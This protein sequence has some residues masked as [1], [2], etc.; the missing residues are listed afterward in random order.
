MTIPKFPI[1]SVILP[2]SLQGVPN[3]KLP[4]EMLYPFLGHQAGSN[5]KLHAL[6][7]WH[8]TRL[9]NDCQKATGV[10]LTY[11]YGGCYRTYAQQ[12]SLFIQRYEPVTYAA[13]LL[14]AS[15]KR[16]YW[17]THPTNKYWKLKPGMAMAAV[18]GTSNHGLGLAIDLAIGNS[19][20][21]ATS[22]TLP[23][24]QWLA[25]NE[26]N[27]GFS[28]ESQSEPWHVRYYAGG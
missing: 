15:S 2:H 12:Y 25:A 28:H 24:M 8:G 14:L 3:G 19:P 26:L 6:A 4:A 17:G 7:C 13:Y 5:G 18:P 10:K 23:I 16:K 11:T 20:A 9:V 27:Y 21:Q 22:I 1:R